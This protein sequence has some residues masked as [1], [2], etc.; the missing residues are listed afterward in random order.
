VHC[1]LHPEKH[2]TLP[3]KL[4]GGVEEA[5]SSNSR[6]DINDL[7]RAWSSC[8]QKRIA[9]CFATEDRVMLRS[10]YPY[11]NFGLRK[12]RLESPIERAAIDVGVV[13]PEELQEVRSIV[14]LAGQMDKVTKGCM[15]HDLEFLQLQP[16][17]IRHPPVL[18]YT[19]R[20]CLV[21]SAGFDVPGFGYRIK[22]FAASRRT[23]PIKEFDSA[24]YTMTSYCHI[25]FAHWLNDACATALLQRP[26]EALFLEVRSDWN[27]A[28]D[29]IKV[30]G[31]APVQFDRAY[32]RELVCYQDYGQ[33]SSKRQRYAVMRQSLEEGFPAAASPGKPVYLRRGN[34]GA[35]RTIANEAQ[36]EQEL[37]RR[38]FE[39]LD[40]ATAD[41]R[42]IYTVCRTAT[43]VVSME[44]SHMNHLSMSMR[45]GTNIIA[46]IPGDRF[47]L[48]QAEYARANGL[49]FGFV[50]VAPTDEGYHVDADDLLRTI[51]VTQSSNAA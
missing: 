35:A 3:E 26:D 4:V 11:L 42:T 31:Y 17:P 51:D 43:T 21:H 22:R 36:L 9:R 5:T 45:P 38:G 39:I 18:R 6:A 16:G 15:P 20:N 2:K 14:Y 34:T 44:G 32:V 33:G 41:L 28:R 50:V 19:L 8:S 1:P 12:L 47:T 24:I 29:Y 27:H 49:H 7:D 37:G 25:Y 10:C 46:L 13:Q 30:F 23:A 48:I 40:V